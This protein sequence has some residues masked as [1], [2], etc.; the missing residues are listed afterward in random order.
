M[1]ILCV[2]GFRH[3][4]EALKES[5]KTL[6]KKF[7]KNGIEFHFYD[8][9]ISYKSNDVNEINNEYKQWWSA[10][11]ANI[12]TL[13]KYD[14]IDESLKHLKE[15]WEEDKYD[16][17]LGFS[18]G[19]VLVQIFAYQIQNKIICTYEPKF[20]ILASMFAI[21]DI[22]HKNNYQTQ[23]KYKTAIM[24]GARDT[25]VSM[26][27]T[28]SLIKYFKNPYTIVHTGGHYVSSSSET[29]YMLQK[30]FDEC[31]VAEA[32]TTTTTT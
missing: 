25:L 9:P 23:L 8:S 3:N 31:K 18:Q 6:I 2:H 28:L 24:A 19:S 7:S 14:T 20:L 13:E 15:R 10:T 27:D 22:N 12:L 32:T 5:M 11:R 17:I 29:Y 1:K 21:T 30:F 16:G 4:S 26:G